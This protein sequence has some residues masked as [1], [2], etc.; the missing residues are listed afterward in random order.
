M[1]TATL[2]EMTNDRVFTVVVERD[3][4]TGWLGGGVVE[5]PGCYAQAPDMAALCKALKKEI[6]AQLGQGGPAADFVGTWKIEHSS[7]GSL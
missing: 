7:Q 4:D 1:D 6:A 3:P 5:L 2:Q